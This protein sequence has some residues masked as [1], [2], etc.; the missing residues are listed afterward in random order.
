MKV[1]LESSNSRGS[2]ITEL[3]NFTLKNIGSNGN[4]VICDHN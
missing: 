2:Q 3:I 4:Y 1:M